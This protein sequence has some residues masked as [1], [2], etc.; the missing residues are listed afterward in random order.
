[1]STQRQYRQHVD[2]HIVPRLGR[3]NL[4]KL[5]PPMVESFRDSLL[6][7]LS[8]ALARKVF[9]SFKSLLKAARYAQVAANV[10]IGYD[11]RTKRRLEVGRDIPEPRE[12]KRLIER[13]RELDAAEKTGARK[14]RE[15][16]LLTAVLTGLRASEL[17]GLRWFDLDLKAHELN[18]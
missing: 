7:D 4:A 3:V 8:R 1:R 11:K 18:V 9:T 12:V 13:A 6:A 17:R 5:T 14:R 10:S 16:L 2:L 15:V